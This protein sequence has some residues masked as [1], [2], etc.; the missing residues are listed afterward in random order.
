MFESEFPR[1]SFPPGES[2]AEDRDYIR[3]AWLAGSPVCA[4]TVTGSLLFG[5]PHRLV[6][7][8]F[9]SA[10]L[11]LRRIDELDIFR[12]SM[13]V[14]QGHLLATVVSRLAPDICLSAWTVLIS[15]S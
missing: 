5:S 15:P 11:F 10:V 14:P 2:Y 7:S 6:R 12:K 9:R 4:W 13:D 1:A 3:P 8:C